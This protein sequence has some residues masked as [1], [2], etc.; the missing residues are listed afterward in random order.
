MRNCVW[1]AEDWRTAFRTEAPARLA[2]HLTGRGMEAR[3]A[4][5]ELETCRRHNDERREWTTAGSLAIPAVT[6]QHHHRFASA[7]IANLAASASAGKGHG[8][9]VHMRTIFNHTVEFQTKKNDKNDFSKNRAILMG[10]RERLRPNRAAR[11]QPRATGEPRSFSSSLRSFIPQMGRIDWG[12]VGTTRRLN[13]L[14]RSADGR[15][16]PG[17]DGASPYL[18]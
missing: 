17:S 4:L 15:A 7:F 8:Y 9:F 3:C 5:A 14:T 13:G 12:G 16:P 18:P 1:L 10:G 6:V 11:V 2:T